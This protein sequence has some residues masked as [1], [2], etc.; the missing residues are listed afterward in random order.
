MSLKLQFR[1]PRSQQDIDVALELPA[2]GITALFGPSGCGKTSLLRAIAGLERHDVGRLEVAGEVWQGDGVFLAPHRRRIGYVFQEASLFAHLKVQGNLEFGW[3]RVPAAERRLHWQ[4]AAELLGLED[5]LQRRT[6]TLSGGERQRVAIARALAVQPRLLLMDEPLS[7]LDRESRAAILPYLERLHRELQLPMIYVSHALEEVARLADHLVLMERGQVLAE[8]PVTQLLS[9]LDL[10][11]TTGP[12][13]GAMIESRVQ[14]FDPQ[15][16]LSTLQF[17][18]GSFAVPGEVLQQG[19]D[20]RLRVLARDVSL[21]LEHQAS[22]SIQ[23]IF[24]ATVVGHRPEGEA[25]VLVRL[26]LQGT[27][28]LA[29]VTRKSWQELDLGDG[30]SVFAQVKSVGLLV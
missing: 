2:T 1:I 25:Q 29:R 9:R 4:E 22:T 7:A 30:T 13:A 6:H 21:T 12:D 18:G 20:V 15:Y 14:A 27:D 10:P 19:E 3:K 26:D 17:S 8:G 11:L 5:L 23:N 28:L 24:A 16:H